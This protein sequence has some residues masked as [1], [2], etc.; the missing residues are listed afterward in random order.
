MKLTEDATLYRNI[1]IKDYD[2]NLYSM[3]EGTI[4]CF[5]SFT[6]T[7]YTNEFIPTAN[8]LGTNHIG[9]NDKIRLEMIIYYKHDFK[10][11]PQG[12]ILKDF[13]VNQSEQ[14]VLLF[15]F[16]FFRVGT[17]EEV[18]KNFYRLYLTI[19]NRN[20]ILEFELK[21]GKRVILNSNDFLTIA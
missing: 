10:N 21:K 4:I 2:L 12:M 6:S 15:P 19:I 16:T 11:A 14:E 1:D 13:S 18:N 8:A 7:S 9:N 5:P 20:D 17:L 3:A